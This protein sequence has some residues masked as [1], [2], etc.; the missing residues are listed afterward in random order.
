ML[1]QTKNNKNIRL[2]LIN[3]VAQNVYD[4]IRQN[5]FFLKLY[6]IV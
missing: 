1:L 4:K 5:L 6:R 2:K 3:T